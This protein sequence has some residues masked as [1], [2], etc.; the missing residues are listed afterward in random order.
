MSAAD[1]A[2]AFDPFFTTKP[3]GK[4]TGLG[5]SMVYGFTKQSGGHVAIYSELGHGTVVNLYLRQ[6]AGGAE[7]S[8]GNK[9]EENARNGERILLVEDD[10]LVR[11][12]ALRLLEGLG[13]R[14]VT[15]SNGPEALELLRK[16]VPCDLLFTDVIMPGGMTG[17]QLAEA[18]CALRP[19]L[20]VLY[21]SGYTENA[22]VHHG[23]VDA[24]INLLHK[25]YRKRELAAKLHAVLSEAQCKGGDT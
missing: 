1:A 3:R 18:A 11:A 16:D 13:Y 14:V 12:H 25:P 21:T 10:D 4:G 7:P 19:G 22:I 9:P 6:V 17:P 15:A 24:G 5:L 2:R 8:I 23:R 20:P